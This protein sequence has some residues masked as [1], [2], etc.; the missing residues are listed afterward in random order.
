LLDST[1]LRSLLGD[2]LDVDPRQVYA[3]M[4]GEHGDSQLLA[5]SCARAGAVQIAA[6]GAQ[7]GARLR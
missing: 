7:I 6:L 3:Y 2:R 5:W 4:L 1:R